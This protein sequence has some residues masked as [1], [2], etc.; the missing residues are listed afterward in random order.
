MS[1][2][3]ADPVCIVG[4]GACTAVGL[5]AASTAAAARAGISGYAEHPY[6]VDG[7][8]EPY[9]LARVTSLDPYLFGAER[10]A[11][12]AAPALDEA[13]APL[14]GVGVAPPAPILALGLPEP[15]PGLRAGLQQALK[16]ALD[17]LGEGRWAIREL[18]TARRGHAAGLMAV[19]SALRMLAHGECELC[20]AGGVDSYV[21]PDALDWIEANGQLHTPANAWGFVPG[22]AAGV[23]LLCRGGT[24]ERLGL[25]PLGTVLSVATATE[26]NRIKTQ[27]ICLGEGLTRAVREALTPLPPEMLIDRTYCDQNGEAYRA[28]EQGFMLAR[29][30]ARFRDPADCVTPADCWGDVGAASGPL[31]ALL[32][33]QSGVNGDVGGPVRLI[34]TSSE[35]G[36]RAAAVLAVPPSGRTC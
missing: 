8:G 15:R 6:L 31:L 28:D 13:L 29:L 17:T 1:S 32:G 35:G 16:V 20:L 11:A 7:V 18:R 33:C 19:A 22:E 9:V 34:W 5:D 4:V 25:R 12:L 3:T 14:R 24:A 23:C 27:S 2:V 36:D 21:D 30:S 10:L 26:V